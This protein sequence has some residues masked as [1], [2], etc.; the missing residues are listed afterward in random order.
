VHM[1]RARA[2]RG[3]K[4]PSS[5]CLMFAPDQL[6]THCASVQLRGV[7]CV[8]TFGPGA[9]LDGNRLHTQ[10]SPLPRE[11]QIQAVLLIIN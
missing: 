4:K 7:R 11:L 5:S 2:E 10:L 8:R 6:F 1:M 9:A 3:A